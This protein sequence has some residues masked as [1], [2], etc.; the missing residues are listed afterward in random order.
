MFVYTYE[1][2]QKTIVQIVK[3]KKPVAHCC[4]SVLSH[5]SALYLK[6]MGNGIDILQGCFHGVGVCD[7]YNVTKFTEIL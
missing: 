1:D 7:I 6:N 5:N 3:T 2:Q 4:K